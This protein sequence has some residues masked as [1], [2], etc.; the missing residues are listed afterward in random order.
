[1]RVLFLSRWFP[2]PPDNGSRLRVFN[3]LGSLAARHEIELISFASEPPTAA[4]VDTL[5]AFCRRVDT[6]IYRPFQPRRWQALL[7]FVSP[8]PRSVIDTHSPELQALTVR[9]AR[10]SKPDLVIASQIDM[11]PYALA[12]P[13]VPRIFEEV[14]L[15][16]PY[17][18]Y[19]RRR[20][21]LRRLRHGLGWWKTARYAASILR[22]FQGCTVV[23]EAEREQVW[24]VLPGYD[25]V[26]VIPNGVDVARLTSVFGEPQADTLIYSGALTY[27]ANFDAMAFFLREVFPR[28][29]AERPSARIAITGKLKGVPLDRL[30]RPEGVVFTGY[31]DDIRPAVAQSWVSVAPLRQGGG[32]RLKILEALALGTPVVATPKGAEGLDLTPGRDLL[33]ADDPAEF[34]AAVVRVLR[35]P[36]LRAALS[37]NGRQAVE[38]KYDW[39]T[40]GRRFC[41]FVEA[42]VSKAVAP[43]RAGS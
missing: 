35:D 25:P 21:P 14:E 4:Q 43:I 33:I 39:Q 34:A 22:A 41:D 23:S 31:L 3:L 11:A 42:A 32:T 40:I 2:F 20:S 13:G 37:R 17:E 38:V 24:R 7:G 5:R 30:P 27:H 29:R 1:M 16:G 28:I 18:N 36:E 15:T 6:V 10:E 9:A 26:A 12:A 8:K 19:V